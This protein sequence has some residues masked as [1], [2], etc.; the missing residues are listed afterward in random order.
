[1]KKFL[2]LCLAALVIY[3]MYYDLHTGTLP[4][5]PK[6]EASPTEQEE[7][8][9]PSKEVKVKPGATVLSIAE[10]L[11]HKSSVPIEKVVSDFEKLNPGVE[12]NSITIG[13]TYR[14]PVYGRSQ[15]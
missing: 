13:K 9:M 5:S 1:M 14:F 12:A 7:D 4:H 15:E 6:A 3:T 10:H 2:G 11:D 8:A